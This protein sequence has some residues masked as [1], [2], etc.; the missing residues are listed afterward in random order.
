M[1]F[2]QFADAHSAYK[3]LMKALDIAK[4]DAKKKMAIQKETQQ[5]MEYFRKAPSIYNDPNI[6]IHA[7]KELPK[8]S[9]RNPKYPAVSD[10]IEFRYSSCILLTTVFT[11]VKMKLSSVLFQH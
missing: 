2:R 9:R 1:Y 10:A 3:E 8:I 4:V 7:P 5:A 11:F 6:Q